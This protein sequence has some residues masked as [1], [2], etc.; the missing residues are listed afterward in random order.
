MIPDDDIAEGARALR[1][2]NRYYFQR[3][4]F[5]K[6]AMADSGLGAT[7]LRIFRE[8]AESA[9][10]VPGAAIAERVRLDPGPVCRR[11]RRFRRMGLVIEAPALHDARLKYLTLSPAGRLL[12]KRL[13]KQSLEA[14]WWLLALLR[15]PERAE[16]LAAMRTVERILRTARTELRPRASRVRSSRSSPSA[17]RTP[18]PARRPAAAAPSG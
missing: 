17:P 12:Y 9:R 3:M 1:R 16:L 10:G 8:I 11:T 2:F 5:L 13:E 6:D 18:V 15:E 7:D 14:A 4:A